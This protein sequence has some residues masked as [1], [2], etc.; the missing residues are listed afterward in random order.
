MWKGFPRTWFEVQDPSRPAGDPAFSSLDAGNLAA[1]LIAVR[2]AFKDN[3]EIHDLASEILNG[4]RWDLLL[5]DDGLLSGGGQFQRKGTAAGEVALNP[6]WKLEGHSDNFMAY[7]TAAGLG[8][9]PA[10]TLALKNATGDRWCEASGIR[11]KAFMDN[12]NDGGLFMRG[13]PT[14][15]TDGTDHDELLLKEAAAQIAFAI[16]NGFEEWGISASAS[17]NREGPSYHGWGNMDTRVSAPHASAFLLPYWPKMAAKN[18]SKFPGDDWGPFD[19]LNVQTKSAARQHTYWDQGMLSAS[20]MNCLHNGALKKLFSKD[21][22][23]RKAAVQVPKYRNAQ[24]AK[25][26]LHLAEELLRDLE[27]IEKSIASVRSPELNVIKR[28][29]ERIAKSQRRGTNI[30]KTMQF[31]KGGTIKIE[32]QDGQIRF[33][34]SYGWILGKLKTMVDVEQ[35]SVMVLLVKTTKESKLHLELKN[36]NLQDFVGRPVNNVPKV[37]IAIP[38]TQG[39]YQPVAVDLS[40]YFISDTKDRMAKIIGLSDPTGTVEISEISFTPMIPTQTASALT[41][42]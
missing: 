15:F 13:F 3:R 28:G 40:A 33:D 10:G 41:A 11:Y 7:W 5:R 24:K 39:A 6:D 9:I 38:N 25:E 31:E 30:L 27:R 4:M 2:Q 12:F 21:P 19:A 35:N 17:P 26:T 22:I 37:K 16:S 29:F 23:S 20:L 14:L 36:P 32:S 8:T 1:G 34:P 42:Y 18:L